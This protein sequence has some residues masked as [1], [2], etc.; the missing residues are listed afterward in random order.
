M[1]AKTPEIKYV[2][3]LITQA[4]YQKSNSHQSKIQFIKRKGIRTN[5]KWTSKLLQALVMQ[6]R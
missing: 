4:Q 5:K 2:Q 3:H 6:S 1:N